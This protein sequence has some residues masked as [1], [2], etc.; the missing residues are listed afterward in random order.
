MVSAIDRN[1][2]VWELCCPIRGNLFHF[3]FR[4]EFWI[5]YS[6]NVQGNVS[7]SKSFV[8]WTKIGINLSKNRALSVL[9][10]GVVLKPILTRNCCYIFKNVYWIPGW[11][12]AE[13]FKPLHSR[14][15]HKKTTW[16]SQKLKVRL[17]WFILRKYCSKN[18]KFWFWKRAENLVISS[19]AFWSFY[20]T[21]YF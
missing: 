11:A 17:F 14:T 12:V 6:F 7:S 15:L 4:I 2:N 13:F 18:S 20:H 1:R 16:K 8:D 3:L 10:F 21:K 19:G 5:R 9:D